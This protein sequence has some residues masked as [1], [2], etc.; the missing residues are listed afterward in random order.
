MTEK[1]EITQ[2]WNDYLKDHPEA[3]DYYDSAWAFGDNP[4]L[5]DELLALVLDGT[6][7]GTAMNYELNEVLGVPLPFIGGHSILLDSNGE[8]RGIVKTTKFEIV[9][10]AEVTAEFAY[11]EGEDDRTL[12][13]WRY[14]HEVY[15]TR[16]LKAY[17]KEFD[18]GMRVIC[19]NFKL[20]H[21]K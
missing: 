9:S 5:A 2:Y 14:E 18:P 16:E 12:E 21:R 19:E 6:K 15:F 4:R 8:P 13:S 17:N 10:F 20:V 3:A 11:S 1:L 7:T